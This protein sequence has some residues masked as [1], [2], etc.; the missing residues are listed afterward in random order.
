MTHEWVKERA[1][2]MGASSANSLSLTALGV[3]ASLIG[4]IL[5]WDIDGH[6]VADRGPTPLKF[7]KSMVRYPCRGKSSIDTWYGR[8]GPGENRPC[9]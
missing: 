6:H 1:Q 7:R 9:R 2:G 5:A 4:T 8:P 3:V